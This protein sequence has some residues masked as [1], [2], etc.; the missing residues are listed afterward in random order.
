MN[1]VTA[2]KE[3]HGDHLESLI[4]SEVVLNPAVVIHRKLR[5]RIV[6]LR[7]QRHPPI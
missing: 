1:T 4:V 7:H 6:R 3:P 5:M 2:D